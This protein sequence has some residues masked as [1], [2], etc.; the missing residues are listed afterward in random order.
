MSRN[1]IGPEP[2]PQEPA[3]DEP[4]H[5]PGEGRRLES[6]DGPAPEQLVGAVAAAM[7]PRIDGTL[8]AVA[9]PSST[10]V[11]PSTSRLV[12]AQVMTTATIPNSGPT[13]IS[14]VVAEPVGQ[15]AEQRRQDEL[16]RV[17]R[18]GDERQRQRR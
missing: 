18:R 1:A 13:C 3:D 2:V 16:G 14:A 9:A 4:D 8:A 15:H 6:G 7:N 5:Q 12:V 11:P 10:R 17:E